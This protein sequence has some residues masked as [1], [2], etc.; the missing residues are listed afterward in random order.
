MA[1][2]QIRLNQKISNHIFPIKQFQKL[3]KAIGEVVI[4]EIQCTQNAFNI[5]MSATE[6]NMVRWATAAVSIAATA[7]KTGLITVQDFTIVKNVLKICGT[8]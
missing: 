4:P 2:R 3:V 5:L 7:K 1:L 8:K 6:E